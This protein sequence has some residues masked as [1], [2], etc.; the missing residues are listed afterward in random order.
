MEARYLNPFI[1]A[2]QEVFNSMLGIGLT[3]FKPQLKTEKT[4]SASVTG[5]LG[6]AG[7]KKGNIALSMGERAV[8]TAY[9]KMTGEW[10][11]SM[12]P[13]VIDAVG[14][15]TNIISGQARKQLDDVDLH[16]TAT[17][18]IV[19]R[20]EGVN[21]NFITKTPIISLSFTFSMGSGQKEIVYLDVSLE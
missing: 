8:C 12:G 11:D 18:P 3:L 13:E 1:L 14:E 9:Q 10:P 2:T 21:I 6:F 16:L 15:L 5:L 20:G 7:D 4:S 19:V 17:I